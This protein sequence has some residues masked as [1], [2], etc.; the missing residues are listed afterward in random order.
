MIALLLHEVDF[1][2]PVAVSGLPWHDG[3]AENFDASSLR[4]ALFPSRVTFSVGETLVM[5]PRLLVPLFDLL[6]CMAWVLPDIRENKPASM[7]FTESADRVLF[8]PSTGE[9]VEIVYAEARSRP[10]A[11]YFHEARKVRVAR[12]DLVDAFTGFL[13]SGLHL[14]TDNVPGLRQNQHVKA[15]AAQ[16]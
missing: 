6:S 2:V 15:L 3:D 9:A 16:L 10:G 13:A 1:K 14:L 5:G 12:E 11:V 4:Y 7:N 8:N